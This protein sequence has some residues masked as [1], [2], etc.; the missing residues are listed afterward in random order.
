MSLSNG[1]RLGPYEIIAAVGAGGM[2]EVYRA[3]D[4]RL[5][6]T[7]AVKV[8]PAHLT[9]DPDL[10]QRFEREARTISSLNH[11]HICA[12]YD[13]G[14]HDGT[15]YLVMEFLE[16]ETLADRLQ[17]G[18]VPLDQVLK[19]GTEIADALDKAHAQGIVHRDLKPANIMLT[20]SGAKLMDFG[21]AKPQAS[22]VMVASATGIAVTANKPLTAE[23]TIVGTF[24]YMAPEQLEGGL[25]DSRSDIFA[26]GAVLYEMTTG[27][28]AFDGKSRVSVVAA[29]LEKEPEPVSAVEPMTPPGLEHVVRICLAKDPQDRW[30]TS[31][32]VGLQLRWLA[33]STSRGAPPGRLIPGPW[34]LAAGALLAIAG[35]AVGYFFRPPD[36]LPIIRTSIS[37]PEGVHL[38][39]ENSSLALSPDGRRLVFA[40]FDR[41]GKQQLW[42]RSL[43]SV[44]AQPLSGTDGATYPFW[45]PDGRSVGFFAGH[46]LKRLDVSSGI[47]QTVCDAPD[48]RGA[49]WGTSGTIVFSAGPFTPLYGV[50]AAGGAPS[51]LTTLAEKNASHR[52]PHFLPDGVHV[53]FYASKGEGLNQH[54]GGIYVL[55][56]QSKQVNLVA[57]ENSE[58]RYTPPGY[59]LFLRKRNLMAQRFD[60]R[61]L[62]T[63]GEAVPIAERILFN[64]FRLTGEFTVS[65]SGLLVYQ[66]GL[67][68]PQSQLT[69]FDLDG[70][71]LGTLGDPAP[72]AGIFL[73]PSGKQMVAPVIDA[74]SNQMSLWMYD[75]GYDVP[76]HFS[77]GNGDFDDPV[78]S[79]DSK[80]VAY[81]NS[82]GKIFIKPA[83]S[84][85]QATELL[86]NGGF[87]MPSLWSP[88]RKMLLYC[89]QGAGGFDLWSLQLTPKPQPRPF[90]VTDA[91]EC[92]GSFSP[93]GKW[94]A[95]IS[96][97]TGRD[98][99]YV[100]SFPSLGAKRQLS[101]D[102]AEFPNWFDDGRRLAYVNA[103]QRLVVLDIGKNERGLEV[104]KPRTAFGG[105]PLPALP[106]QGTVVDDPVYITR[107]GK[108]ML[109]PIPIG[110]G[111]MS[112]LTLV[113]NWT[114]EL[115]K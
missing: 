21:L 89:V 88:D 24:Q 68:I 66:S 59:I 64:P 43:D 115:K 61:R 108:R 114:A 102:G 17:R 56:V 97:E 22:A 70:H 40:G 112:D 53:L 96:D 2:G 86:A 87:N 74:A 27:R 109:L 32:D 78:W 15:D 101:A 103:D 28:R 44:T 51:Q 85:S 47:V 1:I 107:D 71:K 48:G 95:Y 106:R 19:I 37:L 94:L 58:A 55:D 12:L 100:V 25:C 75:L 45:S 20:K 104:G 65:D 105:S 18:R 83:D 41:S 11:P 50:P 62:R 46:L 13:V 92:N 16:G 10:R 33:Q 93:D 57:E 52:V 82:S 72:F 23:G 91:N 73:A 110:G 7:V 81:Q 63:V 69:W 79:P 90:L 31:H 4:T 6:R 38:E 14:H 84:S 49:S 54:N 9:S 42:L 36:V 77:S 30:Q 26:L 8:L 5:D 60:T 29:I 111:S 67:T 3:R 39:T 80:S 34:M 76:S 98:E 113:N 35:L 99:L